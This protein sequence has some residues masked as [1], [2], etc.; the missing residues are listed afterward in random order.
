[1]R[2]L[3]LEELLVSVVQVLVV[4]ICLAYADNGRL[5]LISLINVFFLEFVVDSY[6]SC[7]RLALV[8]IVIL[9]WVLLTYSAWLF[10]LHGRLFLIC[11]Q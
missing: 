1:M 8:L 3:I 10:I 5:I 7:R 2:L 6:A 11:D 4:M 9:I